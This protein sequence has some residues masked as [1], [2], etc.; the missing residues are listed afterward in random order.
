[1]QSAVQT[2][3]AVQVRH[4]VESSWKLL[5]GQSSVLGVLRSL[6]AGEFRNSLWRNNTLLAVL[7]VV[8]V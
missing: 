3:R 6:R 2:T 1:M 8:P 7:A 5:R 4:N